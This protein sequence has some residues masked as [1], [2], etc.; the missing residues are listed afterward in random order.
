MENGGKLCRYLHFVP[1]FSIDTDDFFFRKLLVC[2]DK[3]NPVLF[4]PLIADTDNLY[5]NLLFFSD[6]DIYRKQIFAATASLLTDTEYLIDG[7]LFP[8]V[9]IVD[10][11]PL[12]NYGNEIQTKIF[13]SNDLGRAR[14]P[15]IQKT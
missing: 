10:A 12:L 3:G 15:G 14:K 11:G 1:A 7:E 8:F 4:I 9:L 5:Q 6:H 13:D 2:T